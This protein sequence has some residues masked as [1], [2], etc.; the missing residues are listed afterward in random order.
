MLLHENFVFLHVPKTGGRF[1]RQMLSH[2]I[3]SCQSLP[4]HAAHWGWRQIPSAAADRPVLAF[5]RNPWDWYVSWYSFL[6]ERPPSWF[7]ELQLTNRFLSR[8]LLDTSTLPTDP[9]SAYTIRVND[10]ATTVKL[11]CGGLIHGTGPG[12][13]QDLVAG[14][15]LEKP[16]LEGH[17]FYTARL[18]T[19]LGEG[20]NSRQLTIGRFESIPDDL[21]SFMHQAGIDLSDE[22]IKRLH[23]TN[24]IGRSDRRP[25][26]HYYDR[27]LQEL[28]GDSC[29]AVIDRFGYA[30]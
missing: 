13:L 23:S 11:A 15:D 2:E 6:M 12:D 27:A 18:L 14:L 20:L 29:N 24:P 7:A 30:Y 25:Y 10:F 21:A 28:V 26:R 8:L 9:S 1:I 3:P 5:V 16:L 22:A 19:I 17:D 4:T